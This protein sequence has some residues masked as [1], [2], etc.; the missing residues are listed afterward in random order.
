LVKLGNRR[1]K[2]VELH[3]HNGLDLPFTL[4]GCLPFVDA[5]LVAATLTFAVLSSSSALGVRLRGW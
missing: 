1:T 5:G 4:P 2:A 3:G